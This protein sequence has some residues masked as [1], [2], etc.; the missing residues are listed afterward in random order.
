MTERQLILRFRLTCKE[1]QSKA[2]AAR[3]FYFPSTIPAVSTT[4]VQRP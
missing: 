4:L 3:R 1:T 2:A